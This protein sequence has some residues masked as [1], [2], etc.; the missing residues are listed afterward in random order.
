MGGSRKKAEEKKNDPYQIYRE[1]AVVPHPARSSDNDVMV[2][3]KVY[4]FKCECGDP[5]R[6]EWESA[7]KNAEEGEHCDACKEFVVPYDRLIGL[8]KYQGEDRVF[9]SFKCHKCTRMWHSAYSWKNSSQ[10]CEA[11]MIDI[12]PFDQTHLLRGR[13][14]LLK[15]HQKALCG[16]CKAMGVDCTTLNPRPEGKNSRKSRQRKPKKQKGELSTD[17]IIRRAIITCLDKLHLG[18]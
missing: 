14:N 8:T 7:L 17:G 5:K 4:L 3:F 12:Y 1:Y 2:F 13:R 16:K 9:G 10:K 11:C 6:S 15:G 18:D